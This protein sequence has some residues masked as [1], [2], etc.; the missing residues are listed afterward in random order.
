MVIK[1][2]STRNSLA[3]T[4]TPRFV[5]KTVLLSAL[6]KSVLAYL[7]FMTHFYLFLFE[8]LVVSGNSEKETR[9]H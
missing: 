3:S 1:T 6:F 2:A 7:Y 8:I 9:L 4:F 5:F